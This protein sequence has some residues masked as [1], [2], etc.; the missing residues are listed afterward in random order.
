MKKMFI[1]IT[2][3]IISSLTILLIYFNSSFFICKQ[4]WKYSDGYSIGDWLSL[5]DETINNGSIIRND[6]VNVKVLF[7][8]GKTLIIKEIKS[9]EMGYYSNKSW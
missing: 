9:C 5:S 3:L 6:K 8:F 2:I 7:C 4:Q 1:K